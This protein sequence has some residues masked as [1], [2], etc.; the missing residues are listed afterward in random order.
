MRKYAGV[1]A[2]ALLWMGAG[3]MIAMAQE[4]VPDPVAWAYGFVTPGPNPV[5]PPCTPETKPHDCSRPGRPWPEDGKP[6]HLPGSH[7]TFTISQV[8]S[9]WAPADWFPSEHPPAPDIVKYGNEK[10]HLRACG[11]CHYFNGQGKPENAGLAGLPLNYILQQLALFKS[12]GRKPAD[13]RKANANEMT[14]I[15][16]FLTDK[17]IQEA[18]EYYSSLKWKPWVKVVESDTAPKTRQ[19]PAGMFLGLA[20]GETEPLGERVIE[21]PQNTN[22]TERLRDPHSGF[23]AYVPVGSIAKGKNIVT[24]GGGKTV[25]CTTCHGEDLQGMG[26]IPPIAGR[27]LSYTMRQL[28]N[29]Q[30]GTRKSPIMEPVV[31]KLTTDDLISIV[32]YLGSL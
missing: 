31:K 18:A 1:L 6:L 15:A 16:R 22:L 29:F 14:Q 17:Q 23:I 10:E 5:A 12:G 27:T 30:Q 19:S 26:D 21:V 25:A 7:L 13:P 28:Y 9:F 2:L 24:T 8:Q 11:H 20:G 3:A 4:K 32:A